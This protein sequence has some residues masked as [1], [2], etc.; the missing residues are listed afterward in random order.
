M[1]LER[2]EA[3]GEESRFLLALASVVDIAGLKGVHPMVILAMLSQMVGIV[4]ARQAAGTTPETA[5][6]VVR[7]N[8]EVG[9]QRACEGAQ[10]QG[11]H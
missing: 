8:I 7:T 6:E 10:T 1:S 9:N 3:T 5:M 4:I 11:M 2:Y